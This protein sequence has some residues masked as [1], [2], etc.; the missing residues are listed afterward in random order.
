MIGKLTKWRHRRYGS[1]STDNGEVFVHVT[2]FI[3]GAEP[4]VGERYSFD[5]SEYNGRAV[6]INVRPAAD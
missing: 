3:D 5:I 2:G 6:A 1:I 4:K